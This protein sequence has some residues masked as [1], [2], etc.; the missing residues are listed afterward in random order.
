[1][2]LD[3]PMGFG[4]SMDGVD[5]GDGEGGNTITASHTQKFKEE[6]NGGRVVANAC[7]VFRRVAIG[8]VEG[9]YVDRG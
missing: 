8:S 3:P 4:L 6:R 7:E 1:M 2:S 5:A 9:R